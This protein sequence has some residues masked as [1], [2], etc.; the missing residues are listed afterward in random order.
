MLLAL[1]AIVEFQDLLYQIVDLPATHQL[2]EPSLGCL[3][4]LLEEF[5]IFLNHLVEGKAAAD[6]RRVESLLE[7]S[8]QVRLVHLPR[9]GRRLHVLGVNCRVRLGHYLL[10]VEYWVHQV[11]KIALDL[12]DECTEVLILE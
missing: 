9:T 4:L 8:Y 7:H 3:L 6:A 10:E 12:A 1:P 11:L 2:G 5:I